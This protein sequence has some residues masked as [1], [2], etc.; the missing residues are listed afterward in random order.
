MY[1]F[2]RRQAPPPAL[3]V[4]DGPTREVCT[5]K[6]PRTNTPLQ[7]LALLNDVTFVEAGRALAA[8]SLQTP[9]TDTKRLRDAFRRVVTRA[10]DHGDLKILQRLLDQQRRHFRANPAAAR[11]L[12]GQGESPVGR[13]LDPIELAAWTVTAQ[14]LLT[15]DETVTRR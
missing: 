6:R 2:W 10:P 15:L 5:V 4:F 14:A 3:L 11:E 13:D 9:G 8:M 1:T 12:V 7:A